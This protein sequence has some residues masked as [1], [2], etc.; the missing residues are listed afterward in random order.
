MK[1]SHI[2]RAACLF[3]GTDRLVFAT[4]FRPGVSR[5]H[6]RN[7]D[8][9]ER[10]CRPR[11]DRYRKEHRDEHC[12][13]VTTNDEGAYTVPL[14]QPAEVHRVGDRKR[15]QDVHRRERERSSV[16]DRLTIDVQLEVGAAAEVNIVADAE[17]IER[18]SVTTGTLVSAA[19]DRRTSAGRRRSVHAR[20][21]GSG[22]RLHGRP[23]FSGSDRKRK[24]R[25]FSHRTEPRGKPDQ[26]RR[27]AE[28]CIRRPGR[29][30][31]ASEATQEFK[32]QTNSV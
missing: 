13:T 25:R 30:Y 27:L 6:H 10:R 18:G 17:I 2:R 24:S 32:V 9:S 16:D 4:R 11:S 19:A 15:V 20:D 12:Q 29:F 8:R 22:Y 5:H 14:L 7:R 1:T 21:A 3:T 28:S 26:P 31:A 23:E